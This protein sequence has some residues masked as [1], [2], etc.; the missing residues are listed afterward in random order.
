MLVAA[1]GGDPAIIGAVTEP[2]DDAEWL[3]DEF[4]DDPAPPP[5]VWRRRLLMAV[6]LL[7]AAAMLTGPIWNIVEGATPEVSDGGLELCGFDY[8][9][10][11][12]AVRAAGHDLT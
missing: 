5:P 1:E 2:W 12:D 10:V 4:D 6:G 8:C 7:V 9:V 3:E 11:Q